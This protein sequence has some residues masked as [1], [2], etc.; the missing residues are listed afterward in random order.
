MVRGIM[1]SITQ[2]FSYELVVPKRHDIL[3]SKII[4]NKY[5]K[6]FSKIK[7]IYILAEITKTSIMKNYKLLVLISVLFL[8]SC[9]KQS[10]EIPQ[11]QTLE[12]PTV[13]NTSTARETSTNLA[14]I[15]IE[16]VNKVSLVS[17]YLKDSVNSTPVRPFLGF[18]FGYGITS[19]NY[20]D[21]LNYMDLKY[22]YNGQLPSVYTTEVPQ[23]SGGVDTYGNPVVA[24]NFKTIR[25]P[26]SLIGS[27]SWV[28]V[29]IPTNAMNNDTKRQL[30]IESFTGNLTQNIIQNT[31]IHGYLLNY[32]GNRL[33]K[34]TYRMYTTF[35][36]TTMRFPFTGTSFTQL[37][38]LPN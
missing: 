28:T 21:I 30:K 1:R 33:P 22:F 38:G 12:L 31:T 3:L 5:L 6:N 37:R 15:F 2:G 10:I 36:S 29:F 26:N 20:T 24:Y 25:I 4:T 7:L 17:K 23:T 14:Y 34:G 27:T 9:S 16:P 8:A 32:Q 35:V 19:S 18:A 13:V 11:P